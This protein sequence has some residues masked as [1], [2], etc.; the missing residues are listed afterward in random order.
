MEISTVVHKWGARWKKLMHIK[1]VLQNL[2]G[3]SCELH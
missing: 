1:Y 2:G 3:I